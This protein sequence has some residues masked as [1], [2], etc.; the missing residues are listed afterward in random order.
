MKEMT[1]SEVQDCIKETLYHFVDFCEARGLTYWLAY[2]SLIGAVRHGDIIPWDDDIDL[3]M[4]R[5]DY[6]TFTH[7]FK[8]DAIYSFHFMGNDEMQF[9]YRGIVCNKL[10]LHSYNRRLTDFHYGLHIDVFPLDNLDDDECVREHDAART[11][12]LMDLSHRLCLADP[13]A[14]LE[15]HS[16]VHGFLFRAAKA[17]IGHIDLRRRMM[18]EERKAAGHAPSDWLGIIGDPTVTG[19]KA[20]WFDGTEYLDYGSRKLAVPIGYE[21]ILTVQYGDYMNLPPKD[22]RKPYGYGYWKD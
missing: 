10:T 13:K 5:K 11:Y 18:E 4:P 3:W 14:Y 17:T 20:E 8:D 9:D 1:L 2:G 7:V 16:L 22:Q 19:F 6:E 15:S 12:R 21:K